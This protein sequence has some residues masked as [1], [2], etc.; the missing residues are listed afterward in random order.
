M[1]EVE[2]ECGWSIVGSLHDFGGEGSI[3]V[4]LVEIEFE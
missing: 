3:Q 2:D 4:V 1:L